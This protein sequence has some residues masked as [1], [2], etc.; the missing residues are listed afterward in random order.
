M[1]EDRQTRELYMNLQAAYNKFHEAVADFVHHAQYPITFLDRDNGKV[2]SA[3]MEMPGGGR[4]LFRDNEWH[5]ML[6]ADDNPVNLNLLEE[7]EGKE[8]DNEIQYHS[9]QLNTLL[10]RKQELNTKK[11]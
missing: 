6:P 1:S 3:R 9:N 5:I 10:K 8:I 7:W 4:I 2:C 11:Q